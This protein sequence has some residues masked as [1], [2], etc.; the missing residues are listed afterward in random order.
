MELI[1]LPAGAIRAV[2]GEEIDLASLGRLSIAR[3]SHVEPN[4]QGQWIVDLAPVSG[5]LLGPFRLR[6][7]A[8]RTELAWLEAN[9]LLSPS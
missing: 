2:Y 1:I 8:L 9:W 3:A 6:S 5:P 7:D 4:H